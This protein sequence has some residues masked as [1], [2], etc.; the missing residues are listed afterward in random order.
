MVFL[1]KNHTFFSGARRPEALRFFFSH[2]KSLSLWQMTVVCKLKST[3]QVGRNME[4]Q[5]VQ[6]DSTAMILAIG[7]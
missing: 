3:F 4:G 6:T 5:N 7:P 1:P 2:Y